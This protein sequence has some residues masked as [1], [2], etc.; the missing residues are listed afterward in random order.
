MIRQNVPWSG[1]RDYHARHSRRSLRRA[2]C[3]SRHLPEGGT[4]LDV[5]C[6]YGI[7]SKFLLEAGKVRSATGIE[8]ASDALSQELA[9]NPRFRFIQGDI[10]EIEL[11]SRYDTIFY[12]AVHHH[13][14][15]ERGLN[16]AL[17]VLQTL[18]ASCDRYMF[19]ETGHITEGG[20]W[21]WQRCLR[22]HF[23][24]DEEHLFFLLQMIEPWIEDF[25]LVGKFYIHGV[26]RWL[27][28][29]EVKQQ[30]I[31]G[32]KASSTIVRND[33]LASDKD[34]GLGLSQVRSIEA[35]SLL[36]RESGNRYWRDAAS[37]AGPAFVKLR[38]ALRHIDKDEFHIGRQITHDWAVQPLEERPEDGI[39]F[40]FVE[41]K[42]ISSL[43]PLTSSMRTELGGQILRIYC[44]ALATMISPP[45]R[46][47][48]PTPSAVSMLQIVD[49][50]QNNLLVAEW[51][52]S[53]KVMMVDFER[54]SN[55]YLW[56]NRL[57]IAGI[58]FRL[59]RHRFFALSQFCIGVVTGG[60]HLMRYQVA[61]VRKRV[62]NRQ[63]SL[64]SFLIAELRS[65]TGSI[66]VRIIPSLAER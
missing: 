14:V 23:R 59:R 66:I 5:G 17:R 61:G 26:R 15:R 35:P 51:D 13:I 60:L 8:L 18:T 42:S 25:D 50:N 48:L 65:V 49:L 34:L 9:V 3:I 63:P 11:D 39:V 57:H 46:F 41:A 24:T 56:K 21:A 47:L 10:C 38:P 2:R 32:D 6:N 55:H 53:V 40:P 45:K 31:L 7:T 12:G 28:R 20:R 1:D 36:S 52:G 44:S 16:T 22:R 33:G 43:G 4:F 62:I 58:L 29:V 54:Q 64:L 30:P 19:F 27:I 37:G